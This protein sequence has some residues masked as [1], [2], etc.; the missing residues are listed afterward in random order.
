[1]NIANFGHH[2]VAYMS[3]LV[4]ATGL[5]YSKNW[6]SMNQDRRNHL[7]NILLFYYFYYFQAALKSNVVSNNTV[8]Q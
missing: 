8:L 1:M 3:E 2:Q 4:Q 7:H 5:I 6:T